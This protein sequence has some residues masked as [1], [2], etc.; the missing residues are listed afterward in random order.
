MN[1]GL[2]QHFLLT[3]R[4]N[5]RSKQAIVYGYLVPVLFL[6]AFAS[7]FRTD[8]PLLL[9]RMGQIL[10][11][12]ILGGACFGLPTALVA[13]RE[14]GV[15]RRYRLLPVPTGSLVVSTLAA[16]LVIVA[17]AA[18]LQLVLARLAYH[19][20]FPDHPLHVLLAFLMVCL[21]FLGLGLLVAAL[22]EDVPAVQALGQ[23]LF[24]PMI[25]IGGVA[26]PLSVLPSWAQVVSGFMPGRYAVA[27]LQ[28]GFDENP[29]GAGHG[30]DYLALALIGAA[31]GAVGLRLFRWETGRRLAGS[32]RIW[33]A[34]SLLSWVAVGL[35]AGLTGRLNPP[36]PPPAYKAIGERLIASIAYDDLPGDNELATPLAP[37]FTDGGKSAGMD[38]FASKLK[39]WVPGQADD[40]GQAVRNLIAVASIADLAE[41]PREGVI[42]RTVFT[43]LEANYRT[44]ELRKAL[45]WVALYP[46]EGS[47]VTSAPEFGLPRPLGEDFVRERSALYAKKFLGRLLGKIKAP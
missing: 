17:S 14:R 21:S 36:P 20:P 27:A 22:A 6:I 42:A 9:P 30:F 5:F 26:V 16:R 11:I 24:L 44:E 32:A 40:A 31:A 7:V 35:A 15:W 33:V 25:M 10:T 8:S 2:L 3:L 41:D 12:S 39:D 38:V 23:C 47:V 18:A 19:T 34:A 13:E 29:G 43:Y 4:L 1:P 37:P 45:A 46:N 28:A